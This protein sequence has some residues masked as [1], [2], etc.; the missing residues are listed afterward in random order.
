MDLS[1]EFDGISPPNVFSP[2]DRHPTPEAYAKV[3]ALVPR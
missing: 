2:H 3:A 1:A